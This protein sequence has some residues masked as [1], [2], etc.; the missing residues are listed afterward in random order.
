M[1][2]LYIDEIIEFIFLENYNV[3]NATF[4]DVYLGATGMQE[5]AMKWVSLYK[6]IIQK[7]YV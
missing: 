6:E 4:K 2:T 5:I 3:I 7:K 1:F